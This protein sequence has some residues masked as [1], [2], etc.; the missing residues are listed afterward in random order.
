MDRVN[1]ISEEELPECTETG[2]G[3]GCISP[4]DKSKVH[5]QVTAN[6]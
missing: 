6:E 4:Q 2:P 5:N 1:D 3:L